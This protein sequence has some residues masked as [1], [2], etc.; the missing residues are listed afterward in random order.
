MDVLFFGTP[1]FAVPS[2]KELVDRGFSLPLVVTQPDRPKGRG[3]KL[4]KS[5]VKQAAEE[6]GLAVADPASCRD[7]E[8]I[9]RARALAPDALAVVAYGGILP[10][11]L[12]DIPRLGA[13]NVHPSLLPK[14]RGPAPIQRAV[15][16]GDEVTGVTIMRMD[17]GMDT[18][19]ILLQ[20]EEPILPED[21]SATLS[22]RLAA[23]GAK[24]LADV[25]EGLDKG[26]IIPVRQDHAKATY[27]PALTKAEGEMD[28]TQSAETL[29]RFVRGMGPWPGAFTWLDGTRLK[30]FS[31]RAEKGR[32][33]R[34]GKVLESEPGA[35]A[36][37]T[38]DG[39]LFLEGVQSAG[40]KRLAIAD[41]LRGRP[42]PP[43][44]VLGKRDEG[45]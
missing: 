19:D 4:A 12:L 41:F 38:G 16:S 15:L 31:A 5:P 11:E 14:Y 25:L 18:G 40:G 36:V 2:L 27:A 21:T 10:G 37:A 20:Q 34:P 33:G 6:L 26:A 17:A 1:G 29:V 35:L 9:A 30:V 23:L 32:G 43:G 22:G 45:S 28:W 13:V 44:T 3:K 42:V 7:P 39:V 24:L 8:L